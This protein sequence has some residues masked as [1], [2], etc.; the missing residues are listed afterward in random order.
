MEIKPKVN[1]RLLSK[2]DRL[3]TGTPEGR[4]IEII[5]NA[6]RAGATEVIITNEDGWVTVADN[7]KGIEDFSKLLDLGG[8]GW[9][10]ICEASEDPAGVGLFCLAPRELTIR[11]K[12]KK[13]TITKDGW[14]STPTMVVDDPEPVN[15]GTILR[16]NDNPW[17]E[18]N[19]IRNV[20]FCGMQ[21]NFDGKPCPKMEFL[22][23]E[24]IYVPELGCR[25]DIHERA[26]L[27]RLYR[28][29]NTLDQNGA[30]NFYGQ[31]VA[32][33]I[34]TH[35]SLYKLFCLVELTGE[36]TELRL[37]LP[38]RTKVV[39]NEAYTKLKEAIT[40]AFFRYLEKKGSHSLSY[41]EWLKAKEYGII[42]PEAT[43]D[44]EVGLFYDG[45]G[46][47]PVEVILPTDFPLDKCYLAEAMDDEDE[48][49]VHLLAALG[50]F[51]EPFVPVR[52]RSEYDGYSWANLPTIEEVGVDSGNVLHSDCVL[53]GN[54][55]VVNKLAIT[56][57]ASDGKVFSSEV[58]MALNDYEDVLVTA[59]AQRKISFSA[60]W[61]H[62][63]GYNDDGD[64]YDTQEYEFGKTMDQFWADFIGQNPL[65]A[66]RLGLYPHF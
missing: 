56:A 39:E 59:E 22:S 30:F 51:D 10:S 65:A 11:S 36:P 55:S 18:R 8:S 12:G 44:Y 33:K 43:P 35:S 66:E 60:I 37:M 54:L 25:I 52:I 34:P 45:C 32:L 41:K 7:G 47:S 9:D 64:T 2:A 49:N 57:H 1:E 5:Q 48:A 62:L 46:P 40:I 28:D 23:E 3:F 20:V 16:F 4:I 14:I 17:M 21:V 24:A 58:C 53:S 50:N 61:Y 15:E 31:L 13:A 63:G 29:S 27:D 19:V 42:L 6:R 26:S 38:A